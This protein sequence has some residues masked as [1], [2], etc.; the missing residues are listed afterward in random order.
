MGRL[1]DRIG[2]KPLMLFGSATGTA[3]LVPLMWHLTQAPSLASL[4][5]LQCSLC[6]C[7]A[8]YVTSCGPMAVSLFPVSRRALGIGVG[9]NVGVIVFGAFA[10]FITAWLIHAN[11]DKMMT[12]WYAFAS[13]LV[14]V[15]VI[16]TLREPARAAPGA[17]LEPA[18]SAAN[19]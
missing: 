19:P 10:P 11:G 8:M 13:G 3:L 14:S 9:Y 6:V 7:L 1:A 17:A 12:A 2:C 15:F 16:L 5:L 4:L 18:V